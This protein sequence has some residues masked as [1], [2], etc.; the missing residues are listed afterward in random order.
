MSKKWVS[1]RSEQKKKDLGLV[2]TKPPSIITNED[3]KVSSNVTERNHFNKSNDNSNNNTNRF[4]KSNEDDKISSNVTERNHFNKSNDNSNN[5]TNRFNNSNNYNNTNNNSNN[6]NNTNNNTNNNSNK[7]SKTTNNFRDNKSNERRTDNRYGNNDSRKYKVLVRISNVPRDCQ[8]FEIQEQLEQWG[9]ISNI[10][11]KHYDYRGT[12]D[13]TCIFI[14]FRDMDDAKYFK[15][16]H[17][18]TI[19]GNCSI[20][21]DILDK[22]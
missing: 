17:H 21:V 22:L 11:I 2:T 3:D 12:Y 15:E 4:N 8:V 20:G 10:S 18:Q 9:E 14:N 16:A 6:Y 5:N 1:S 13:N 19:L 7:Y